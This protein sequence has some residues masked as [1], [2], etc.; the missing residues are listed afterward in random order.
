[1]NYHNIQTLLDARLLTV[2][3]LPPLQ[4]ENTKNIGVT[5]QNFCRSTLLPARSTAVT[6]GQNGKD[7]Y[8]GLYQ[9]DLFYPMDQGTTAINQMADSVIAAFP[10]TDLF[11]GIIIVHCLRAWR[12]VGSRVEPFYSVP[13]VVEWQV[14]K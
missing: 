14:I 9:I 11:D 12:E 10:R 2:V 4:K 1:M 5:G 3:D 7:L 6:V 8:Q 13:V